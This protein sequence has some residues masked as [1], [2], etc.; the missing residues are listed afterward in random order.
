MKKIKLE[1]ECQCTRITD[2]MNM[3]LKHQRNFLIE[4]RTIPLQIKK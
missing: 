3:L 1:F 4:R 2:W